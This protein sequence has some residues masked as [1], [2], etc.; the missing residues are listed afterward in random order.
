MAAADKRESAAMDAGRDTEA[1]LEE[2][3]R[4]VSEA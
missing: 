2:A 1:K 3:S 4:A